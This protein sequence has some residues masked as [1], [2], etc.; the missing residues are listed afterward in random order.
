MVFDKYNRSHHVVVGETSEPS[1]AC[2]PLQK[3][4]LGPRLLSVLVE[5][6]QTGFS[7]VASMANSS[8]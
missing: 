6:E 1:T 4:Q 7:Q 8:L 2:F 5:L 3:F